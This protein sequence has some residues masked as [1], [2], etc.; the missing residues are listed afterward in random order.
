MR[1]IDGYCVDITAQK[2]AEEEKYKLE[3]QLR[4]SQK[5]EA[6]GN[7]AGG[8]SHDFNNLLHAISGYVQLL[9]LRKQQDDPDRK[10]LTEMNKASQRAAKLIRSCSPSA[11]K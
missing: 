9:L 1:I 3:E 4:H 5:M 8:I 10:Y 7:L 6:I 2:D 11:E